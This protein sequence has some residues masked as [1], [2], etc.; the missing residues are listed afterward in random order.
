[1][2]ESRTDGHGETEFSE[3][4]GSRDEVFRRQL[5]AFHAAIVD[6]M[7]PLTPAT[8]GLRDIALLREIALATGANS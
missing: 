1:M 7:K 5:V 8:E 3:R 4:F 2:L 6:G